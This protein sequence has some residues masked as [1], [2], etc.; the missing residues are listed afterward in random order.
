MTIVDWTLWVVVLLFP[1]GEIALI[2][3]R[4]ARSRIARKADQ[5]STAMLWRV[6]VCSLG[7]AVAGQWVHTL[8]LPGP[9]WLLRT[10]ALAFL[11]FG[12]TLRWVAVL[13]LGRFFT[14]DVA[15]HEQHVLV[16]N[17]VYRYLRH[18]SYAGLLL[19]F[20]GLGVFFG[21]WLSL[22]ALT[23]PVGL[24]V[25]ARIR[26]EERAL[27][28]GLGAAYAEYCARTKRLVPGLY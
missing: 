17:G 3:V 23:L 1:A 9:A 21:S 7:V 11:A 13:H 28:E 18:P 4:R 24:A 6:I 27:L 25:L 19:A 15:I 26:R 12:L 14:V 10:L 2:V 8:R 16:E 5:G 22:L 20:A